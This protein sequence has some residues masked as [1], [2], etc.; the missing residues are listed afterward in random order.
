MTLATAANRFPVKPVRLPADLRGIKPGELPGYLLKPIRPYGR[1]HPLAAQAWEAL[2]K[3]AHADGIRPF[4]PASFSDT[5]RSLQVQRAGF[6]AR[7]TTAPIDTTSVRIYQGVKYYLK[8]GYA[9]MATPGTSLHNIALAVDVFEAS[10]ERL[11]WMLANCDDYGFCWEMQSEPWHIR[12]YT[13]EKVPL[14]VQRY[15][16]LH[17]DRDNSGFD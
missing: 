15:E 8:P 14:K 12:Y 11:E 1:L 6:L 9:P 7:Y 4:K 3:A 13:G 17:A 10:G 16:E 5:Y 2:R